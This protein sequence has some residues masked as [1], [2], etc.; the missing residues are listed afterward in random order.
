MGG[1][2]TPLSAPGTPSL[3]RAAS[4]AFLRERTSP[5]GSGRVSRQSDVFSAPS[6]RAPSLGTTLVS[7]TGAPALGAFVGG[8]SV[9]G[10]ENVMERC[11]YLSIVVNER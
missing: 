6:D 4:P 5:G 9:S 8:A 10:T 3:P 11:A 7:T 1:E 2:V